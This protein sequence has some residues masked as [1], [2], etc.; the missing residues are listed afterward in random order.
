MS[1]FAETLLS[2]V[3]DNANFKL[4][5]PGLF[6][7]LLVTEILPVAYERWCVCF[8]PMSEAGFECSK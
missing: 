3:G 4:P 7:S 8:F 5:S 6:Q 1:F 2:N